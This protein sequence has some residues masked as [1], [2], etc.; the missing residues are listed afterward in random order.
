MSKKKS[1]EMLAQHSRRRIFS[2]VPLLF[3]TQIVIP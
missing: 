1:P 3:I 2:A